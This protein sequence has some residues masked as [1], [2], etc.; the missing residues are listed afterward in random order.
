MDQLLGIFPGWI[1][2]L[3]P[4]LLV[5]L[6]MLFGLYKLLLKLG[7]KVGGKILDALEKPAAAL[8]KQAGA[9]DRLTDS[10]KDYVICDRSD[11]R[12]MIIL[13]K[14]ISDRLNVLEERKKD[15]P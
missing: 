8:E 4:G 1:K 3:G 13:L 12:E 5:A 6:I 2:E 11:H 15:G 9:M 10:I 14:L 7:E